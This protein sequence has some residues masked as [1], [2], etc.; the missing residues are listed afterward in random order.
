MKNLTRI[1]SVLLL[2]SLCL[3]VFAA[4]D[5]SDG[6]EVSAEGQTTA[7][8]TEAPTEAPTTPPEPRLTVD[9]TWRIVIAAEA[10]ERVGMAAAALAAALKDKAGFELATVTDAEAA[11]AHELVLGGNAFLDGSRY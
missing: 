6:G 3:S 11:Q 9:G 8:P 10:D 1:L 4:C 5:S 2:L 7:I